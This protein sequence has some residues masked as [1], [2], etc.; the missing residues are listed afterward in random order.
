M[1]IIVYENN[2]EK[3]CLTVAIINWKD[4]E[5]K[6]K[7]RPEDYIFILS[8]DEIKKFMEL[9]KQISA[10]LKGKAIDIREEEYIDEYAGI[11]II[12]HLS[13]QPDFVKRYKVGFFTNEVLGTSYAVFYINRSMNDVERSNEVLRRIKAL[14]ANLIR[15]DN[16]KN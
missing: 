10:G 14:K 5:Q 15:E 4:F 7:S 13:I 2:I 11:F 9:N 3:D 1:E 8:S 12:V 16:R 6:V